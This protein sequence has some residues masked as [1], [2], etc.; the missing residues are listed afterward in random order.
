MKM[1]SSQSL[2]NFSFV[3][4]KPVQ[5]TFSKQHGKLSHSSYLSTVH[6]QSL[7]FPCST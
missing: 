7:F 5:M 3:T 4:L 2:M 1:L 6:K